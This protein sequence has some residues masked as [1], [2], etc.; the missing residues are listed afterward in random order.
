MSAP[1]SLATRAR[2][3]PAAVPATRKKVAI[4]IAIVA[5][6]LQGGFFAGLPMA[7]WIPADVMDIGVVLILVSI[8]LYTLVF[9]FSALWF[10]HYLLAALRDLRAADAL[11]AAHADGPAAPSRIAPQPAATHD[12]DRTAP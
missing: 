12:I 6:V 8:W 2:V 4:A 9:A 7:S 1:L 10:A 11:A 3:S 5:D